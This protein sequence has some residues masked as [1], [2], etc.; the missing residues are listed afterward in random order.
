M[1]DITDCLI[2][3]V[4]Q[5]ALTSIFLFKALDFVSYVLSLLIISVAAAAA[6]AAANDG[7]DD[8]DDGMT[9]R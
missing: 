9:M 1:C 3:T 5:L 7:N 2:S 8:N 4:K 6:A